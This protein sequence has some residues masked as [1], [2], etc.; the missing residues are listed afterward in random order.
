MAS[1]TQAINF[2]AG[3]IAPVLRDRRVRTAKD[4]R[5]FVSALA[6]SLFEVSSSFAAIILG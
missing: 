5:G 4:L 1:A 3:L 2:A 6:T